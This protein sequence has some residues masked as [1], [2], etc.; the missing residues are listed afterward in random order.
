MST[1]LTNETAV[2]DYVADVLLLYMCYIHVYLLPLNQVEIL[3][4][5]EHPNIIEFYGEASGEHDEYVIVTG[6]PN[7]SFHV[8]QLFTLDLFCYSFCDRR[9]IV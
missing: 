7:L 6:E 5:L 1:Y 9:L 2:R 4:Q 3:S 8:P